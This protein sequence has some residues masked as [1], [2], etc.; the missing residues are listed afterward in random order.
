MMEAITG[1]PTEKKWYFCPRCGQKLLIYHNAATCS[2]VYMKCKR[3]GET[4]EIKI[5]RGDAS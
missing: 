2:G 5:D 1:I 3:C 4:V